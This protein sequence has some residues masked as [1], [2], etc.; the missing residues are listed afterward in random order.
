MT[1]F[2][3]EGFAA[4]GNARSFDDHL[5]LDSRFVAGLRRV[6]QPVV[7]RGLRGRRGQ[8]PPQRRRAAA[9]AWEPF[10]SRSMTRRGQSERLPGCT[11][12]PWPP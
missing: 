6:K 5:D 9:A 4:E 2:A 1:V 7:R 3:A 8:K 12:P 10:G 11:G